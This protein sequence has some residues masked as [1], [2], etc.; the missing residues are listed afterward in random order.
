MLQPGPVQ[1]FYNRYL[2]PAQLGML[3][4]ETNFAADTRIVETAIG[5]GFGIAVSQGVADRGCII[6]G[7]AFV[8]ITRADITLARA[9]VVPSI[10]VDR[11]RQY[12]NAGILTMGDIWVSPAGSVAAGDAVYYNTTTGQLGF[13]GGTVIEDA[14]WMTGLVTGTTAAGTAVSLAV[15]R[16]GNIAGAR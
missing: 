12:D 3:A 6:G 1:S 13:S 10:T 8:G 14:R 11:Y 4:D 2:I 9:D 15:V 7:T 5:I 16:L